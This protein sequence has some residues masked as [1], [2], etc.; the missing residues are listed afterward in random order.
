MK[1]VFNVIMG[2][3]GTLLSKTISPATKYIVFAAVLA[4]GG[5]GFYWYYNDTQSRLRSNAE[6]ISKQEIALDIQKLTI[7]ELQRLAEEKKVVLDELYKE[8]EEARKQAEQDPF[9]PEITPPTAI[10]GD[11]ENDIRNQLGETEEEINKNYNNGLK[12]F[13]LYGSEKKDVDQKMLDDCGLGNTSA[14]P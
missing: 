2:G 4:I 14:G 5:A 7:A 8:L 6:L 10:P 12:C 3:I 13:E 1:K 11:V 9:S